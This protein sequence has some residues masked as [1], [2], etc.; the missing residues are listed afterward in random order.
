MLDWLLV[1][2]KG[3]SF[4]LT[5][6]GIERCDSVCRV[7]QN[8]MSGLWILLGLISL[9]CWWWYNNTK[10]RAIESGL[11][12]YNRVSSIIESLGIVGSGSQNKPAPCSKWERNLG[13]PEGVLQMYVCGLLAQMKISLL[14]V[15]VGCKRRLWQCPRQCIQCHQSVPKI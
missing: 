6:R 13:T 14:W 4:S 7:P 15:L 1:S 11:S 10:V 12:P 8:L 9:P 5:S 2:R 3:D